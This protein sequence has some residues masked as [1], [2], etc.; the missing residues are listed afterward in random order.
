MSVVRFANVKLVKFKDIDEVDLALFEKSLEKFFQKVGFETRLE[1]SL[2][3]YAKGGL[4]V[5]HEVHGKLLVGSKKFFASSEGWKLFE[6]VSN[7]LSSLVKEFNKDSK[8]N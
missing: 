4:R 2:K 3:D 8:K 6:V 7:V 1:L 5:Q